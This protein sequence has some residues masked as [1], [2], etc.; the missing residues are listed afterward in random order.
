MWKH[1]PGTSC[2][3]WG[4]QAGAYWNLLSSCQVQGIERQHFSARGWEL[5]FV[6]HKGVKVT[7]GDTDG[8]GT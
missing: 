3:L 2:E 8:A 4:V 1:F 7:E 6:D 5:C